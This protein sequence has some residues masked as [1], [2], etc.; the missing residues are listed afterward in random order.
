MRRVSASL[1]PLE[2]LGR[3]ED[4]QPS[5]PEQSDQFVGRLD[6][7]VRELS[8]AGG[9]LI[10]QLA[11]RSVATLVNQIVEVD[12]DQ[13]RFF[14]DLWRVVLLGDSGP[15]RFLDVLVPDLVDGLTV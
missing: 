1:G 7:P 11:D 12:N 3:E 13:R 10:D 8:T 14:S 6:S 2:I 15:K 9:E 5:V 4:R